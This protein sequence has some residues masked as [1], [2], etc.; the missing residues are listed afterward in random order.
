MKPIRA[1]KKF[2]SD[3]R[4][5]S[6]G[7]AV[8]AQREIADLVV[9]MAEHPTTWAQRFDRVAALGR[10][11]I[12]EVDLAGGPRLY[13]HNGESSVTLLR[14][15][16]HELTDRL[17]RT[18]IDQQVATAGPLPLTFERDSFPPISRGGAI[19]PGSWT[20]S[21]PDWVFFLSDQQM[22]VAS[23]ILDDVEEDLVREEPSAH[24]V[25]G[26]PG[27]GKTV[28]LLW[29]LQQLSGCNPLTNETW[30]VDLI[31]STAVINLLER[32]SGWDLTDIAH[33]HGSGAGGAAVV[34]LD[35][36]PSLA[37]L[38]TALTES[39]NRRRSVVVG[40]DVLQIDHSVTD[41]MYFDLVRR[42]NV[43]QHRLTDCYR[44]KREVGTATN[45][46]IR[47]FGS[48]DATRLSEV[49]SEIRHV[50]P[51]GA[52]RTFLNATDDDWK[53]TVA[54]LATLRPQMWSHWPSVLIVIDRDVADTSSWIDELAG[55]IGSDQ[56]DVV[57][58]DESPR[59][60]GVEYQHAVLI[61]SPRTN[62]RIGRGLNRADA[63][64][65]N[66]FRLLRIPFSRPR[67]SITT[68]VLG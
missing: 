66:L 16:D 12:L 53:A 68:L 59:I 5:A 56:I 65:T 61:L 48:E 30:S 67:D 37:A 58:L 1:G 7:L 14:M 2:L 4:K 15:G 20:E 19:T 52:V 23:S 26:G 51:S 41:Q 46:V 64:T 42:F 17:R 21:R 54:W 39:R 28:V 11:D 18:D 22:A 55:T 27:T 62:A 49:L 32:A 57:R 40:I 38:E 60:R 34:L 50:V 3:Y 25:L 10:N 33:P 35:D 8:R 13:L 36:P 6:P 29:L 63:A 31:A 47:M 9:R 24:F 44:Q 43:Q 45:D